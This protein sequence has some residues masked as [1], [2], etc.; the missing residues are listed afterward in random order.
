MF[1]ITQAAL[2]GDFVDVAGGVLQQAPRRL[3]PK[4]LDRLGRGAPGL[5]FEFLVSIAHVS[6]EGQTVRLPPALVQPIAADYVATALT[7]V[8]LA[9]P[10]NRA[11][12]VAGP[13]RVGLATVVQ[14]YL[15]A[16]GDTRTVMT[17]TNAL[18][19]GMPMNDQSLTPGEP[20]RLGATDFAA[21]IEQ[22]AAAYRYLISVALTRCPLGQHAFEHTVFENY[23]VVDR[24]HGVQTSQ[25]HDG[26]T[27]E[28]VNI[29]PVG[30]VR[31][32]RIRNQRHLVDAQTTEQGQRMTFTT[33]GQQ[34]GDGQSQHQRPQCQMCTF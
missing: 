8:A 5:F 23:V 18:Y 10:H 14:R 16:V 32:T 9:T 31:Q 27:Q 4:H 11:I 1:L 26:V 25:P 22:Q 17:D 19:F 12:E 2:G 7:D 24:C 34:G 20:V 21:W 6:A 29:T 33:Q 28:A 3:Q 15:G 13:K 30:Q